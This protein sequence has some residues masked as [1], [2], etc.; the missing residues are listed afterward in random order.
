MLSQLGTFD[1]VRFTFK[2]SSSP[3]TTSKAPPVASSASS[4]HYIPPIINE[5]P[6]FTPASL[7]FEP[8]A[9]TTESLEQDNVIDG[10]EGSYDSDLEEESRQG[11]TIDESDQDEDWPRESDQEEEP[12]QGEDSDSDSDDSEDDD[13]VA[14]QS[15]GSN[16]TPEI[17]P[18]SES[19]MH[20]Q[21]NENAEEEEMAAV[22]VEV[23][24]IV[25]EVDESRAVGG[26]SGARQGGG[27]EPVSQ[28]R[29]L[30][31]H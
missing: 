15:D 1:L 30:N 31:D 21:E 16:L 10:A 3:S 26:K 27:D 5:T 24:A 19:H 18:R 8:A 2:P 28:K 13:A 23:S 7:R 17:A 20:E 14:V 11:E 12:R 6:V 29:R 9:P 22:E 25:S 4:S